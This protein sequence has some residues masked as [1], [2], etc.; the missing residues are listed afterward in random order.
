[1]SLIVA[2]VPSR[3]LSVQVSPLFPL[4]SGEFALLLSISGVVVV[5]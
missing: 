3:L 4:M 1:M 2:P 5:V